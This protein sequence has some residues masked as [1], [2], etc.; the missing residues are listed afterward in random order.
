MK[1]WVKILFIGIIACVFLFASAYLFLVFKGKQMVIQRLQELTQR[2]VTVGY[3]DLVL[4]LSIE[5]KNLNIQGLAKIDA[6]SVSPSLLGML[7]GNVALNNIRITNPE[8]TYEKVSP[9]SAALPAGVPAGAGVPSG[10]VTAQA[11]A[12]APTTAQPVLAAPA[13]LQQ[14]RL[15]IKR[16]RIKNGT[17]NFVDHTLDNGGIKII[18]KD[19]YID[20]TNL[21]LLPR[22]AIANFELKGKIPWLGDHEEGSVTADGWLNLYKKDM[23][24][25]LKIEN[26]DGIYLFPYY[27]K[28]VDLE[29]ARIQQAK[30]NFSSNIHGLNNNITADCHLELSD[31]QFK[32]RPADEEINKA[33]KIAA[34]VLDVFKALNQGKIVLDFTIR[35]KMT[36][37]EF[38]FSSVKSAFEDR[39]AEARRKRGR[40]I[41]TQDVLGL[42]ANFVRGAFKSLTDLT[43]A[44]ID[45]TVSAGKE[46]GK[47]VKEAFKREKKE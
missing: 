45:G 16:L 36:R 5:I 44:V 34:M 29:K 2:K 12:A 26:I 6:I 18:V 32:E 25:N 4:P 19:I 10:E 40:P 37:P 21:Y 38:G 9:E 8:V 46:V 3:F 20:L 23:E 13:P 14:P 31:I 7:T 35:T 17:L 24:A 30:L 27:S 11:S 15:I 22:S 41:S 28:W 47:S 42:P 1:L 33:E 43:T 39:L